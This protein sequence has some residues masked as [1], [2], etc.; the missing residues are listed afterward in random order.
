[1]R[2]GYWLSAAL[3]CSLAC[4]AD[5]HNGRDISDV[6]DDDEDD[7]E[8]DDDEA[9][10]D[11]RD[12]GRRSDGSS[13]RPPNPDDDDGNNEDGGAP[14]VKEPCEAKS[15][16]AKPQSPDILIVL[17]RSGSMVGFPFSGVDRWTPSTSAVV[18]LTSNLT[19][20]VKFGLM[21]FPAAATAGGVPAACE[22]G[23]VSVP[24]A[25]DSAPQ[26]ASTLAMSRPDVGST[27]TASALTAALQALDVPP[28][29]DCDASKKYVLLVTDGAPTCSADP[30]NDTNAAID[31]LTSA[32]I[33][34]YV[35]G[36]GTTDPAV[37][38]IM[39]GFAQHGGTD[40]HFAVEN[41]QSLVAELTRITGSLVPCEYE[42]ENDIEDAKFV[43]VTIDGVAYAQGKDWR[44]EGRTIILDPAAGAC[45]KLRDAKI[46][47]LLI[48]KECKEPEIW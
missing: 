48:T 21:L 41:E 1:M 5:E 34:T 30:V 11:G 25:L 39:D 17:D 43:S 13:S 38:A 36:Y 23:A 31:A 2:L 47:D 12:A 24:I 19:S 8:A 35:I 10:D 15:L 22:P 42:L 28:C 3:T 46:H 7:D 29:G 40:K 27:P 44:V 33:A 37:A 18:K 20:T 45:S 32:K 26:I 16:L 14:L 9:D 4:S 6:G